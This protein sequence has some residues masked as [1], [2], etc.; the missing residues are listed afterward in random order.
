M[1]AIG[2]LTEYADDALAARAANLNDRQRFIPKMNNDSGAN[3]LFFRG[4][5]PLSEYHQEKNDFDFFSHK[6]AFHFFCR[7]NG[8]DFFSPEK[9]S[10]FF[11][12]NGLDFSPEKN[13]LDFSSTET[14]WIFY[15]GKKR[16]QNLVQNSHHITFHGIIYISIPCKGFRACLMA[17]KGTHEALLAYDAEDITNEVL[18]GRM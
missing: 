11:L 17:R 6:N 1:H 8:F 10:P 12:K 16:F 3:V 5:S 2:R 15:A 9:R 13:E 18:A 4:F 7:R 14:L